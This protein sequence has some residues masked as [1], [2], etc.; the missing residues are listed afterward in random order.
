LVARSE[1]GWTSIGPKWDLPI[2]IP[3]TT[4]ELKE[5]GTDTLR[6]TAWQY[7]EEHPATDIREVLSGRKA[8][9]M[10]LDDHEP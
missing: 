5:I 2:E 3:K 9:E 1:Q 8:F 7:A 4:K 10:A 6:L